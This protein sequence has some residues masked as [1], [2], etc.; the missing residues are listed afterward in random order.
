MSPDM[1]VSRRV[2][3]L[4]RP[5]REILRRVA[6]PAGAGLS[7]PRVLVILAH[8][9][10]E[11]LA[12]GA[13]LERFRASRLLCATDGAPE[14]GADA[15]RHGFAHLE[16]YRGARREE[17]MKA[18]EHAQIPR[19]CSQPLLV[20]SAE[21][22]RIGIPDQTA[23]FHL[24][25]L[26]R[27]VRL[28]IETFRPEAILT[29]PYEG[30]HPDHD[31]CAFA[32]QT[33]VAAVDEEIRPALLEAPFYH[34]GPHGIETGC[35][36]GGA[37]GRGGEE[38]GEVVHR[39]SQQES[40]RKRERLDCFVTQRETLSQFATDQERFRVSSGYDFTQAPHPGR[41]FYENFSWGVTGSEFRQLAAQAIPDLGPRWPA[42]VNER[43]G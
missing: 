26:S 29:H 9:D 31:S 42:F 5:A 16:G 12:L 1:E 43:T 4:P 11:V 28:E 21:G 33:A 30:G 19:A 13:R 32:V 24:S 17:L 37:P 35:F 6:A 25:A 38:H 14:D 2:K 10:D 3:P 7:L 40:E 20:E 18:L 41:L 36:L 22:G 34:A 23:A 8:P 27:Q 15:R 39:L